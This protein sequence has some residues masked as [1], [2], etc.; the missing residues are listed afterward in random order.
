MKKP[1]PLLAARW[2]PPKP[3]GLGRGFSRVADGGRQKSH[4]GCGSRGAS[5]LDCCWVGSLDFYFLVEIKRF[6]IKP[7]SEQLFAEGSTATRWT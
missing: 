2:F 7:K 3:L 1:N 5:G 4:R 6:S